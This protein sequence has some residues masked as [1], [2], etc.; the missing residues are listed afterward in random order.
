M[1]QL[2][3]QK[4]IV[5]T[6]LIFSLIPL[7]PTCALTFNSY[8]SLTSHHFR[9]KNRNY[10]RPSKIQPTVK[11]NYLSNLEPAAIY[12]KCTCLH[13]KDIPPNTKV[14]EI[15]EG[16]FYDKHPQ[17]HMSF[18]FVMNT[19]NYLNKI[20]S[21]LV[22][23][24]WLCKKKIRRII[25]GYTI[26]V[27]ECEN[28]KYYI[29]STTNKKRR[30]RQHKE[31][32]GGSKW[33]RLNKPIRVLKQYRR[34]P[35]VYHLG[36]EAKITAECML[37]YGINNVR[38]AMF[39]HS[40]EYTMSDLDAL[41]GFIG[42]YNDMSYIDVREYLSDCLRD[43]KY[44]KPKVNTKKNKRKNRNNQRRGKKFRSI[45]SYESN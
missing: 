12:K 15:D 35:E 43:S 32:R 11:V 25:E 27:L 33:T 17:E 10:A 1:F 21:T 45:D 6:T 14:T 34:V 18:M 38:G 16:N 4:I 24:W 36:M 39:G 19:I 41:T 31:E 9:L 37:K 23:Y 13:L 5:Y 8:G 40:V 26:Y 22:D 3:R 7:E 42:H 28:G 30:F 20:K 29:G 2:V 44:R